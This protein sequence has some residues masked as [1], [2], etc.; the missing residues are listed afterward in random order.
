[1]ERKNVEHKTMNMKQSTLS[2]IGK[3]RIKDAV[4]PKM[5]TDRACLPD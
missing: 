5:E 4:T 2:K 3:T 1:M